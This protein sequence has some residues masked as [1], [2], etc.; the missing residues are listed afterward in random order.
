MKTT[1]HALLAAFALSSCAVPPPAGGPDEF[2]SQERRSPCVVLPARTGEPSTK[3]CRVTAASDWAAL[4]LRPEPRVRGDS[5]GRSERDRT[6]GGKSELLRHA[7][8]DPAAAPELRLVDDQGWFVEALLRSTADKT[9]CAV[10]WEAA[11][12]V[13]KFAPRP[14]GQGDGEGPDPSDGKRCGNIAIIHS[15]LRL[16]VLTEQQAFQGDY[17]NEALVR[18]I[19]A[20]HDADGGMTADQQRTAYASFNPP[21][22][23]IACTTAGLAG[24]TSEDG[25]VSVVRLAARRCRVVLTALQSGVASAQSVP[26]TCPGQ[27]SG[28]N[29][30]VQPRMTRRRQCSFAQ[31]GQPVSPRRTDAAPHGLRRRF[32]TS[33]ASHCS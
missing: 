3:L 2:L 22:R 27:A 4:G 1:Q 9:G 15:L 13:R 31:L 6:V 21:N 26:L 25:Q 33:R 29:R 8:A 32:P 10:S 28:T 18:G 24:Q 5:L 20:H 12:I 23:V 30:D 17:L 7:D 16:G 11:R 19:D 14:E